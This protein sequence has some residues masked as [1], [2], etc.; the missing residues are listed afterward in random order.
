MTFK[1]ED[2]IELKTSGL[3]K[4]AF[5]Q[6]KTDYFEINSLDVGKIERIKYC[7]ASINCWA[8]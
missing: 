8:D 4:N 6:G 7:I 5:E 3:H 1:I 2:K